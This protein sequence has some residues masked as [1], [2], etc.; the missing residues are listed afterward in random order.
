MNSSRYILKTEQKALEI[1]LNEGVY[2]TFAEIGAGQEVARNFFQAGGAAGTI[3]KTMSA[4]DKTY[5][6]AIYG[7]EKKSRYVC[8][9]RV[10]K[11]LDH[12]YGLMEDRLQHVRPETNFFVFADTVA[13][14]NYNKTIQGNGW[15]GVR[16]QLN[17]QEKPNDLVL[18]VKMLDQDNKLQQE[19][20]G[21]LGVNMIFACYFYKD[22]M[23]YFI[24]SLL[25]GIE[26]R[27][28]I[29]MIRL[30]GPDFKSVDNRLLAM[31]MVK[32]NLTDVTMFDEMGLAIHASE[33]LYKK[34]LMVVRGHY[35]PPTLVTEDVFKS[36]YRQF[37]TDA[38]QEPERCAL[39]AELTMENLR[40]EGKLDD[41]DFLARAD[42]LCAM[43]Y[44][45]IVSDCSNHQNLINYLSDF[46]IK[47]LG[48][49]IG[50]RELLD[51]IEEKY[52]LNQDGRLLVA[53]GELFTRNIKIYVYPAFDK[54][55]DSIMSAHNLPVPQ[56]IRFLYQH[57]LD[58]KQVVEV[59][60]YNAALLHI[61]PYQVLQ[62]IVDNDEDW[63]NHLP[64][65]V[66]DVI[67]NKCL[68]GYQATNN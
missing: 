52:E 30:S 4:Y 42:M 39:V 19:A 57:L 36:S 54:S 25:D 3:A 27:V 32:H 16:F 34:S 1:N 64:S 13:A 59:Q 49:V 9:S 35:R 15:L 46:K 17:P 58:S 7:I 40:T 14:I 5:S 51:I 47:K 8:E 43:G 63:E 2:G 45:V 55:G 61:M 28:S 62:S 53:F 60:H 38:D 68:L 37:L 31:Y 11:M 56:G 24:H 66:A 48:L 65:E 33:W 21:V 50:A 67:K 26:N 44:K 6:D 23:E 10:Y 22:N 18:H 12:E 41:E 29:D 20:I